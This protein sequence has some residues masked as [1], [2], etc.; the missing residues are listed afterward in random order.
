M[1]ITNPEIE[2]VS[3]LSTSS[4]KILKSDMA[5]KASIVLHQR[6]HRK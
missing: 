4:E 2:V 3:P 6:T 1:P 5:H